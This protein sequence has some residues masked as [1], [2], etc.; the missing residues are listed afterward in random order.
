MAHNECFLPRTGY[1]ATREATANAD[2]SP[3]KAETPRGE[4][5]RSDR[6]PPRRSD[7]DRATQR[8]TPRM[9]MREAVRCFAGGC[10]LLCGWLCVA[11]WVA[12]RCFVG[13][14]RRTFHTHTL[15]LSRT[16]HTHTLTFFRTSHTQTL[17]DFS[18]FH[19]HTHIKNRDRLTF[20]P[21]PSI[22]AYRCSYI[23]CRAYRYTPY[24]K[25]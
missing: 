17:S 8:L 4:T 15:T 21:T 10:A 14:S 19:T 16:F 13:G 2:A 11:L 18:S 20:K 6:T 24:A 1:N 12:V 3:P 22:F 25:L 9:G 7:S 5:E 23:R